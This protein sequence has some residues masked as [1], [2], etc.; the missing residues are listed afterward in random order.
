MNSSIMINVYKN[1]LI[2]INQFLL[3][4]ISGKAEGNFHIV[5]LNDDVEKAYKALR[6]FI[7]AELEKQKAGGVYVC[8]KSSKDDK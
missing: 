4:L 2:N 6:D 7:V 5:V 3:C 1:Q 8:L